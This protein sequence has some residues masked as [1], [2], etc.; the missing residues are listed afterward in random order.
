[1]PFIRIEF[2]VEDADRVGAEPGYIMDGYHDMEH[3]DT[4]LE[5]D[6]D[7]DDDSDDNFPDSDGSDYGDHHGDHDDHG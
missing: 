3:S 5:D 2:K 7:D 4:D 1:M 6:E